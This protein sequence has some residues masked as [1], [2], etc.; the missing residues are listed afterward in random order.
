MGISPISILDAAASHLTAAVVELIRSVKVRPTSDGE[1]EEEDDSSLP[2]DGSPGYFSVQLG[3]TSGE[4]TYSGV[5]SPRGPASRPRSQGRDGWPN[6]RPASRNGV[7]EQRPPVPPMKLGYDSQSHDSDAEQLKLYLDKEVDPLVES[8]RRLVDSIQSNNPMPTI[9]AHLDNITSSV[10]KVITTTESAL[11]AH[12][13]TLLR[14]NA[15][16]VVQI[17][18][19]CRTNLLKALN[20]AESID[21]DEDPA[22]AKDFRYKLRPL[23][24]EVAKQIKELVNRVEAANGDAEED[25]R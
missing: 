17:L 23:A 24:F 18:S 10:D 6:R 20:Q 12:G 11:G 3:R 22:T 8:I 25:F 19:N 9:H 4:S 5:S 7:T 21:E 16:P 14:N 2:T 15:E 1:L 13:N